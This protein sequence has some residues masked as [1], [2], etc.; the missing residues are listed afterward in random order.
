LQG[1]AAAAAAAVSGKNDDVQG[2]IIDELRG[3]TDIEADLKK[4][5]LMDT[6]Q[7]NTKP[8]VNGNGTG[9]GNGNKIG[10]E[11]SG[12]VFTVYKRVRVPIEDHRRS[13]VPIN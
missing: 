8:K 12:N 10:G 1:T 2:N 11:H 13:A 7:S 9:K 3:D 6:N 5:E 4:K